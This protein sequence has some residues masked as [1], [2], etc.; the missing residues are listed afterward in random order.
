MSLIGNCIYAKATLM[1]C[2]ILLII[3]AME[4]NANLRSVVRK[5]LLFLGLAII[6]VGLVLLG[7]SSVKGKK[8]EVISSSTNSWEVSGNLTLGHSY[9]MDIYSSYQ[10]RDDW[11]I[12]GGY[13]NPQPVDVEIISPDGNNTMLQAFF[14]ATA[15]VRASNYTVPSPMPTM[16][17]VEY[18]SV[19]HDSIIVD[20]SYSQVRF[21][22]KE[23]GNYTSRILTVDG[24]NLTWTSGPPREMV[25]E[26][27]VA[28]DLSSLTNLFEASGL[29]S[30]L[31]GVVVSVWTAR[32][33]KKPRIKRKPSYASTN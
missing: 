10:W 13:D 20:T 32:T 25:F 18:S 22:V 28:E 6:V 12:A 5:T 24:Y 26:E 21:A 23:G 7:F 14:Y 15:P 27:E 31:T 19:D 3:L 29:V 17:R 30:L 2:R 8:L 11:T 33:G 4:E 9:V 16:I 1:R